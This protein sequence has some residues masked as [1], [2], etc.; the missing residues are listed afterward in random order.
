M[1]KRQVNMSIDWE[2]MELVKQ[3]GYNV[4]AEV[5]NFLKN[6]VD[7]DGINQQEHNKAKIEEEINVHFA[8]ISQLKNRLK[9]TEKKKIIEF[10]W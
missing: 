6:L 2:T 10:E 5:E 9:E 4:S 3:K 8:K 1:A 7:D